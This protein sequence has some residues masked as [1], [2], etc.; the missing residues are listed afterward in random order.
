MH[1]EVTIARRDVALIEQ[2]LGLADFR[3]VQ[4][5]VGAAYVV[6]DSQRCGRSGERVDDD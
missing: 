6:C 5:G 2:P 1:D 4:V 3:H